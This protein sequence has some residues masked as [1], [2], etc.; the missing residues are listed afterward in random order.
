ML[1]F[2]VSLGSNKVDN[3]V[4]VCFLEKFYGVSGAARRFFAVRDHHFRAFNHIFITVLHA[5][6]VIMVGKRHRFV[7]FFENF[8]IPSFIRIGKIFFLPVARYA[9][10]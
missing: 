4:G 3:P 8:D 1:S 5:A 2:G 6:L 7:R 10:N 9:G